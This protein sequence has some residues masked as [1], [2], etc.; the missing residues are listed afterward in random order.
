[1]RR[2]TLLTIFR[3]DVDFIQHRGR[4]TGEW[5][6]VL[7]HCITEARAAYALG[8]FLNLN[9]QD[10]V[11]LTVAAL[12][13]DWNK[14]NEREAAN[15]KGIQ[16]YNENPHQS[17]DGLWTAGY[18][19]RV[20]ELTKSVGHTAILKVTHSTDLSVRA[21]FYLDTITHGDK[22]VSVDERMDQLEAAPRYKELNESGRSIHD[23]R[24][25]FEMQR[26]LA[27]KIEDELELNRIH[28]G[29]LV[30]WLQLEVAR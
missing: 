12:L 3:R 4:L 23:G 27:K 15:A 7:D 9:G 14:R 19:A 5:S 18:N 25:Y 11:N 17:S 29:Q 21:M 28:A 20:I 30:G 10:H 13:H 8:D 24:T 16:A 6:N 1:M 26:A 2:T 22:I